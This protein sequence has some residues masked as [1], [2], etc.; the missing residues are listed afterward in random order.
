MLL[1][2][3]KLTWWDVQ[4]CDLVV[5]SESDVKASEFSQD[6]SYELINPD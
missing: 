2:S 6:F 5:S 4:I 3:N 1:M